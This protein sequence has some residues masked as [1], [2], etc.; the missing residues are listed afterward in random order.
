MARSPVP[1]LSG[2]RDDWIE[3]IGQPA[4]EDLARVRSTFRGLA[5]FVPVV[6]VSGL[7]LTAA[8]KEGTTR[9]LALLFLAI[10]V[11]LGGYAATR[12]GRAQRVILHDY[13]LRS[14]PTQR[15]LPIDVFRDLAAFDL[16]ME[17]R[18]S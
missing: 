15:S 8:N 7:L 13:V 1:R 14:N 5:G 2:P 11:A 9:A 3:R 10:A 16:S 17:R 6:I 18:S 12:F 4:Y